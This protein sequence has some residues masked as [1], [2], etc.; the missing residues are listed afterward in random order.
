M[1]NDAHQ[2]IKEII[3]SCEL[4]EDHE[5]I[6]KLNEY[7]EIIFN[8]TVEITFNESLFKSLI[9]DIRSIL[10]KDERTKLKKHLK[11]IRE[12]REATTL[13]TKNIKNELIK[14]KNKKINRNKKE[15]R[16]YYQKI[17]FIV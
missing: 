13:E 1:E 12:L 9:P 14:I 15:L 16:D 2:L 7:L 4:I 5:D 11:Y 10:P 17:N 8:K 3:E 6:N